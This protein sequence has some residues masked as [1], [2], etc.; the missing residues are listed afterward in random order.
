MKYIYLAFLFFFSF[1]NVTAQELIDVVT[2]EVCSCSELKKEKLA[3]LKDEKLQFEL[4]LC[5]LASYSKH[6]SEIKSTYGDLLVE[7]DKMEKFGGDIGI[8]MAT[9]C[10]DKLLY[11]AGSMEFDDDDTVVKSNSTIE[12]KIVEIKIDQFATIVVKDKNGRVHNF[13]FLNYFDTASLFTNDEI[14]KNDFIS[15]NYSESEIYDPK[16]K[17]F[18]YYKI[19][20]GLEKK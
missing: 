7:K 2:A 18:R 20:S 8:K 17:E 19:I 3:G 4:G 15:V 11:F 13:L 12:G 6:T 1:W 16:N 10:P 5:I 9:I 14:K